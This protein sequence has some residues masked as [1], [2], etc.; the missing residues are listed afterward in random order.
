MHTKPVKWQSV[1]SSERESEA[2]LYHHNLKGM[3]QHMA[4]IANVSLHAKS[5]STNDSTFA[6]LLFD[7]G[8]ELLGIGEYLVDVAQT[9]S[10][11]V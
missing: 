10:L 2:T 11:Y 5:D 1:T 6:K 9:L 3:A 8:N 4:E 7:C